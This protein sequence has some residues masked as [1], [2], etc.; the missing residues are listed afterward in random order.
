MLFLSHDD[1]DIHGP[2][3]GFPRCDAVSL[4]GVGKWEREKDLSARLGSLLSLPGPRGTTLRG[5]RRDRQR[6]YTTT[7]RRDV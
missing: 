3:P 1:A 4:V 5:R 6:R 7:R 2:R